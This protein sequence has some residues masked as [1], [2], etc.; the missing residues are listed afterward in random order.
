MNN[1]KTS[2]IDERQ[3]KI[4]VPFMDVDKKKRYG[5][6]FDAFEAKPRREILIGGRPSICRSTP[7]KVV[8]DAP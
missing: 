2:P 6:I 1:K 7:S 3:R 8:A 4:A 5:E